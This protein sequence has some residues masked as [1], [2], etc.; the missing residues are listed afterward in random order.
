MCL[1]VPIKKAVK[2]AKPAVMP[3]QSYGHQAQGASGGIKAAMR[4][5]M[6]LSTPLGHLRG[7][8]T[9]TLWWYYGKA[10]DP[11]IKLPMEQVAEW[12]DMWVQASDELRGRIRRQWEKKDADVGEEGRQVSCN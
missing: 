2:L 5:N 4:R 8:T 1:R 10:A 12:H 3:T 9:T 11:A 7:C 6:K